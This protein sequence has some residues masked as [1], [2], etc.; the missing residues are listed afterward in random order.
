MDEPTKVVV[1][2]LQK[3][4]RYL[5]DEA[6]VLLTRKFQELRDFNDANF[7]KHHGNIRGWHVVLG[8]MTS[9]EEK[10]HRTMTLLLL[11]K[12]KYNR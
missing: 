2:Y 4:L 1:Q 3:K 10:E 8:Q 11:D 9:E 7:K 5:P 6:E 12:E